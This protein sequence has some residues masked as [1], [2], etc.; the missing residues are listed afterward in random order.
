M[1]LPVDADR[2]PPKPTRP[3]PSPDNASPENSSG[4][5]LPN[6]AADDFFVKMNRDFR[7]PKPSEEAVAAAL[8]A[9]QTLAGDAG[10]EHDDVAAEE[11]SEDFEH[12]DAGQ[13]CPKCAA[14]NSGSNRF[15]GYC[16]TT[17][18]RREKPGAQTPPSAL[19]RQ[20]AH[21]EPP[22]A[23]QLIREGTPREQHIHQY[24]HHYFPESVVKQSLAFAGGWKSSSRMT[25]LRF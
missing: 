11:S 12:R 20:P 23:E 22:S 18:I 13:S 8:H 5:P 10:L 16:G 24:H 1:G 7:R 4:D 21:R 6:S 17:L 3:K 15:C 25:L 9:I 14:I 19:L 2:N